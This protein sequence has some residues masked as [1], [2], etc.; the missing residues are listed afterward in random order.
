LNIYFGW[1]AGFGIAEGRAICE[2]DRVDFAPRENG[3]LRVSDGG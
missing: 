2:D 3:G 1:L